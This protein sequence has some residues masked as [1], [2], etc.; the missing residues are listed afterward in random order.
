M[1]CG[2]GV[3]AKKGLYSSFSHLSQHSLVEEW[4]HDS[5]VERVSRGKLDTCVHGGGVDPDPLGRHPVVVLG[6]EVQGVLHLLPDP[7]P[8]G[9]VVGGLILPVPVSCGEHFYNR[10]PKLLNLPLLVR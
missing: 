8:H 7:L 4:H 1:G 9:P 6:L 10:A 2:Q 3:A 5:D